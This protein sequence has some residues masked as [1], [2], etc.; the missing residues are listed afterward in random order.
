MLNPLRFQLHI[1]RALAARNVEIG[2]VIRTNVSYG[3]L[4]IVRETGAA[5]IIDPVTAYGLSLP[6][7]VIRPIDVNVPFYW[8]VIAAKNR[9]LRPVAEALMNAVEAV[10][11][12]SIAGFEKL[13]PALAGQ[14]VAGIAAGTQYG[15][16]S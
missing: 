12:R 4:Q 3:A 14:L 7:I 2:P 5:A 10:A 15:S 13:D 1:A 9:P 16:E 11:E 6:G 8:G